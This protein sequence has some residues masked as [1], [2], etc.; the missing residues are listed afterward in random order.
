MQI[1]IIGTGYIGGTLTR[2]L[3]TLG[4]TVFITNKNDGKTLNDLKE[5]FGAIPVSLTEVVKNVDLIIVT[6][7]QKSVLDLPKDLFDSV[8]ENTIIVDTGN[9]YPNLRDGGIE[10]LDDTFANSEWVQNIFG[11][12]IVKAFN[13]VVFSSLADGSKPKGDLNRIGLPVASDDE[14]AKQKVMELVDTLGFE[15]VDGGTIAQSWRQQPGSPVYC[16]DLTA[17]E[18]ITHF[19]RMGTVRTPELKEEIIK[20]RTLQEQGVIAANPNDHYGHKNHG[21]A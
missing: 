16:T 8:G 9:F 2:K 3:T 4:Y 14:N 21:K 13:S 12:P 10:G 6:I 17:P 15:P 1:G 5:G 19:E 18:I 11:R 20:N 7:P